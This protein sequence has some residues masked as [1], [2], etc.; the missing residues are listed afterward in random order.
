MSPSHQDAFGWWG[1][2][3]EPPAPCTIPDLIRN[4]TLTVETVALL[5]TLLARRASLVV[6]AGPSGAGKTTLLTALLD[7]LPPD[8]RRVYLRGCYEPFAFLDDR[9]VDPDNTYLLINEISAHLPIYLWGPG[10]RRAL[11]AARCGFGIAATAHATSVEGFVQSLAGYPLRVPAGEIATLDLIVQLDAW[12]ETNAVRREV[13]AIS[14]LRQ[15]PDGGGL[16]VHRLAVRPR[17]GAPLAIDPAAVA[18][19]GAT[20]DAHDIAHEVE[21]R[22]VILSTLMAPELPPA[23]VTGALAEASQRWSAVVAGSRRPSGRWEPPAGIG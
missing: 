14:C 6:T 7:L 22:A 20:A 21:G 19:S 12:W 10:V 9:T 23:A 13:A 4:G 16:H 8:T 2:V 1:P 11:D 3:W 5:W 17:R 18:G 15:T